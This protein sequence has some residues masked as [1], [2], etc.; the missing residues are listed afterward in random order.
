M[1]MNYCFIIKKKGTEEKGTEIDEVVV[2][3]SSS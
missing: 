2:I 3:S 1:A